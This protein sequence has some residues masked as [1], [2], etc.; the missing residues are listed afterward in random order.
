M[1]IS[2]AFS[3][4]LCL[5]TMVPLTTCTGSNAISENRFWFLSSLFCYLN[6]NSIY[7]SLTFQLLSNSNRWS[8][9][10]MLVEFLA[11]LLLTYLQFEDRNL[12]L[13]AL[14]AAVVSLVGKISMAYLPQPEQD[15]VVIE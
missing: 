15:D 3:M 5:E 2:S 12:T 14:S 4:V 13:W 7:R 1:K 6:T 10:H 8:V 9:R 11:I